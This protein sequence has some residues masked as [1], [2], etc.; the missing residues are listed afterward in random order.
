MGDQAPHPTIQCTHHITRHD[1]QRISAG[2]LHGSL[3]TTQGPQVILPLIRD[4]R[5]PKTC[6]TFVMAIGTDDHLVQPLQQVKCVF[7]QG[8]PAI[9][10]QALV[11]TIETPAQATGEYQARYHSTHAQAPQT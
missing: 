3:D 2:L 10:L 7:D 11:F 4:H 8:A 9:P 5:I 6:V 1:H